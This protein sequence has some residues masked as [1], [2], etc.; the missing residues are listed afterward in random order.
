M[1]PPARRR[2]LA[3]MTAFVLSEIKRLVS[4]EGRYPSWSSCPRHLNK[5]ST[6]GV[7]NLAQRSGSAD[8]PLHGGRVP[9]WL[10]DRVTRLGTVMC[11]AI[12]HHYGR[13]GPI[14]RLAHPSCPRDSFAD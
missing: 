6:R 14:H 4:F 10:G 1:L 3:R 13:D 7:I 12:I 11:Q 8:L 2:Q 9:K 5:V